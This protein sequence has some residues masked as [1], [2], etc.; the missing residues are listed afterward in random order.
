MLE[1]KITER[2]FELLCE[3]R[4]KVPVRT[5]AELIEWLAETGA[6]DI[7][8]IVNV[9]EEDPSLS[10]KS[11]QSRSSEPLRQQSGTKFTANLRDTTGAAIRSTEGLSPIFGEPVE[12]VPER[13]SPS[14]VEFRSFRT[15]SLLNVKPS[16]A[17]VQGR[18]LR[19]RFWNQAVFATIK[20][21]V[22]DGVAIQEIVDVL[23]PL[24]KIGNPEGSIPIKGQNISHSLINTPRI[25]WESIEKLNN[26]WD[27]DV[28]VKFKWTEK[29]P[30]ELRG[31]W[32]E[33]STRTGR[34]VP[35][36]E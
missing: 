4:K 3:L 20:S 28:R 5:P 9:R 16:E 15:S 24:I 36:V 30:V 7:G 1:I 34:P 35:I 23:Y 17:Y 33:I 26:F 22:E 12:S 18:R 11:P 31:N 8:I 27:V 29:A 21:L 2:T 19:I 10:Q 14:P 13:K 6:D 32:Y 25:S